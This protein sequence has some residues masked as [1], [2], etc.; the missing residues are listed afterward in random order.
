MKLLIITQKVD[1]DD[2]LLG[3]SVGW[4]SHLAEK[5]DQINILCLQKGRF[6][7]PDNVKVTSLG[8][9][10]GTSKLGQLFN[11]YKNI[12]LL[13]KQYDAVFVF[14]NAIWVVLGAWMWR[15]T[16]KKIFLWYAHKTITW[17]HKLAEKFADGIFTSTPEGFRL[18]SNKVMIVGQGINVDLFKPALSKRSGNLSILSVG[19]IAPIKDY[20]SL[21]EATKILKNKGMNF[22]VTVIG[23]PVFPEDAEY[24]KKLKDMVKSM[25]LESNFSF[26]GKIINKDLPS[27]YQSHHIYINLS[28]TGSLDK[29]I[30]E[31][32]ASGNTV[33]S[34]NDAASKFLP[35]ELII[36]GNDPEEISKKI[37]DV[38]DRDF[39]RELREYVVQNHSLNGL[40]EKISYNIMKKL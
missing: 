21:I 16:K 2:Q 35:K 26:I 10:R 24:E 11:F 33:L 9:D 31:A 25:N 8:K 19:R 5:F 14:M 3:F 22:S 28:K 12:W 39:S 32:M 27:Y 13:R 40:V 15:L 17:K 30:V 29:T 4:L 38:K 36:Q 1:E 7:L 23:E 37:L 18:P 6:N 34:S 20:E